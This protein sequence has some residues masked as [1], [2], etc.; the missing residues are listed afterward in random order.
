MTDK[1]RITKRTA[2]RVREVL[3][4]IVPTIRDEVKRTG[5]F[6]RDRRCRSAYCLGVGDMEMSLML[7]LSE[8]EEGAKK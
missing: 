4:E 8:L 6:F 2:R 7:K 5:A 1:I 3:G